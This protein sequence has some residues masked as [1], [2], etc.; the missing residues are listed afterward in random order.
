M[1]LSQIFAK[2]NVLNA[3]VTVFRN[4]STWSDEDA[5]WGCVLTLSH[6]GSEMKVKSTGAC[7][8]EAIFSAF[9]KLDA[10]LNS[11]HV[12]KAFNLPLLPSTTEP[13]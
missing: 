1:T 5:R 6:E 7:G 4:S 10:L 8:D 11:S 12:V 2:L 9:D 13:A 3:E